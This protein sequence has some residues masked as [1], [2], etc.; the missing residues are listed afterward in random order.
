MRYRAR[1]RICRTGK[2]NGGLADGDVSADFDEVARGARG[3]GDVDAIAEV[4]G[5]VGGFVVGTRDAVFAVEGDGV[6]AT[7]VGDDGIGGVGGVL[8]VDAAAFVGFV[9]ERVVGGGGDGDAPGVSGAVEETAVAVLDNGGHEG[10]A[11]GEV[12]AGAVELDHFEGGYVGR[13]GTVSGIVGRVG[14]RR[15]REEADEPKGGEEC[16]E[17]LFHGL[18]FLCQKVLRRV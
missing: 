14:A 18:V 1:R 17:G 4:F 7:R 9:D 15:Q 10:V 3:V 5:V 11:D 13:M 6:D 2:V 12:G 16:F 8:V